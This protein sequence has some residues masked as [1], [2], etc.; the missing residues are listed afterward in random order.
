MINYI[1]GVS[2]ASLLFFDYYWPPF[3]YFLL[4]YCLIKL[5]FPKRFRFYIFFFLCC[6]HYIDVWFVV[7]LLR[8]NVVRC[9]VVTF[10]MCRGDSDKQNGSDQFT[11]SIYGHQYV[12]ELELQIF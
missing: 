9:L 6:R 7:R 3:V 11:I 2:L 10:Y 12:K 4:F 5:S 1:N 8:R